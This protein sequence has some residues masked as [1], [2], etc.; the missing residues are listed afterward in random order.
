MNFMSVMIMISSVSEHSGG[1]WGP[2]NHGFLD[3]TDRCLEDVD[4]GHVLTMT[5]LKPHPLYFQHHLLTSHYLTVNDAQVE[6]DT[7]VDSL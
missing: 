5:A 6:E 3:S 1:A 7:V 2:E 4:D